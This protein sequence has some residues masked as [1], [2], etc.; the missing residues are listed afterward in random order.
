M[1]NPGRFPDWRRLLLIPAVVTTLTPSPFLPCVHAL[2]PRALQQDLHQLLDEQRR[3]PLRG[4]PGVVISIEFL[5]PE[6][7][8]EGINKEFL[9]DLVYTRLKASGI[10]IAT[11][12]DCA[13]YVLATREKLDQ[14][15]W[16]DRKILIEGPCAYGDLYINVNSHSDPRGFL[17]SVRV[18]ILEDVNL[19]RDPSMTVQAA[20]WDRGAVGAGSAKDLLQAVDRMIRAFV[21]DYLR[22][23]SR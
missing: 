8:K 10:R 18:Q 4:L 19:E 20:V 11:A 13:R 6:V 22:A 12:E 21:S 14:W 17:Y 15:G 16:L 2:D 1:S 5:D 3:R 23:N 9:Y 7:E